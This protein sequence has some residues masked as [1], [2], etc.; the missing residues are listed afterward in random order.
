ML[1]I[2]TT[3]GKEERLSIKERQEKFKPKWRALI[4]SKGIE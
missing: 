1:P 4:E 2:H 3:K